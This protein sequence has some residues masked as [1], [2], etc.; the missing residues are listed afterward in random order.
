MNWYQYIAYVDRY[1][2]YTPNGDF[3]Y[4][5][6]PVEWNDKGEEV[7]SLRLKM[8]KEP[9]TKRRLKYLLAQKLPKIWVKIPENK[10]RG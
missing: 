3:V 8:R 4:G 7:K 2:R 1:F 5:S 9:D 10:K 6:V